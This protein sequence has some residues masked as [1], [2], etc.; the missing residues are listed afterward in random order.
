M[1]SKSKKSNIFCAV[2]AILFLPPKKL[3][4]LRE[5][6]GRHEKTE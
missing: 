1:N 3:R 6:V 4:E 2:M 5:E